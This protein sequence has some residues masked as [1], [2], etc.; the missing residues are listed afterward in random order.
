[1]WRAARGARAERA[2]LATRPVATAGVVWAGDIDAAIKL[3]PD[4]AAEARQRE[5]GP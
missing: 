2:R 4:I 3:Q 1:V 5:I